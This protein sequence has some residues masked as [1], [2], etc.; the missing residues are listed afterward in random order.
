MKEVRFFYVP[1][2]ATQTELPQEEATHA[3][4][5]LRIQAG[6]ELFL[7]DG[8]G[9]FYR[10]EVSLATNKRCIYEVKEVMPQQPAWRGHIHLAIAPTKMMDRIEWMTEKATEIGFD[11]ISF[12]NCKFSERKVI[13][14]DR[15]D[16]IVVSAVKQSH[17]AWKPVVN[18]LQN[19]KDF[20][21]T[22]RNGRKF[23]CHCYEE[24]EK[25]DFFAEISKSCPADDS[26][27]AAQEGADDITVLVGPEGDF[28]IDEVRLALENGYESVSLGTSRLRTET[29]G[30]VA[31]NMCH[32]ARRI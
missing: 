3:L 30:L 14:T 18:E 20:I 25:K 7:M 28:S 16:K 12:L 23:I 15:V 9:V 6:D 22:P 8:K 1:D 13:R 24:I 4:R 26:A 32:L 29:A 17:K 10:S 31:V 19:F 11:E 27:G 5:V 21:T 2:A